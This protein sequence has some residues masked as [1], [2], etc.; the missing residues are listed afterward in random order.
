MR[1]HGDLLEWVAWPTR[2]RPVRDGGPDA[3]WGLP[4][5]VGV[6]V[7][8]DLGGGQSDGIGCSLIDRAVEIGAGWPARPAAE[9]VTLR[10]ASSRCSSGRSLV[11]RVPTSTPLTYM[12]IPPDPRVATTW[13]HW[14]S[15]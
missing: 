7:V 15:L 14:P 6:E 11:N 5:A 13:C 12:A 10:R 8:G 3:S 2:A 4:L 1:T 9:V